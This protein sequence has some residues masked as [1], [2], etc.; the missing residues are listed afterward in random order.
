[1]GDFV[2]IIDGKGWL[3]EGKITLLQKGKSE[4]VLSKKTYLPPETRPI[5]L[6]PAIPF[7]SHLD[8]LIEKGTELGADA[9]WLYPSERSQT[10]ST[11]RLTRLESILIAAL[12]QSGRLYLPRLELFPS[13]RKVPLIQAD[14]YFGDLEKEAT[15]PHK[16]ISRET[17]FFVGPE[18]GY[19]HDET[20]FLKKHFKATGI[21]LSPNILRAETAAIVGAAFFSM[22]R[23]KSG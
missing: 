5:I 8:F 15:Y 19:T 3:G 17:I 10:I 21:K 23:D 2:E 16:A 6:A 13:L 20:L 1:V 12:K 7:M 11:E 9:F 4:I 18:G 14:Y 22:L